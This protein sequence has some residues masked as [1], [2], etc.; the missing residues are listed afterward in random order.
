TTTNVENANTFYLTNVVPQQADL[1]QGVWAQFE[2]TLG[3]SADAGR[4]VYIMV[5]PLYSK[6]HGLTF[7]KDEGKVAVPDST[8]K[9]AIIGPRIGGVPFKLGDIQTWAD[10]AGLTVLAVNMPNVAGVRND[11]WQKYLT[12]VDKIEA[13]TGYDF[14]SLLQT[15]YQDAVEAGDHPPVASFLTSGTA[16]EGSSLKFDA[17]ASTD[18]DLGRGD[19]GR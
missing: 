10:L 8:W 5:G 2:K 18:P 9:I 1:N 17:S 7:L 13:A 14:L 12:T 15:P 19:L 11:P 4:A 3:D 16:N 6:T